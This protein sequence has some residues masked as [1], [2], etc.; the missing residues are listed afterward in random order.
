MGFL[1]RLAD[2]RGSDL[3]GRRE[4]PV[5]LLSILTSSSTRRQ[6]FEKGI[7]HK[8]SIPFQGGEAGSALALIQKQRFHLRAR[9]SQA[10]GP[11]CIG[12]GN[13]RTEGSILGD[14]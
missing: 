3:P 6:P 12:E 1:R 11:P 8:G 10:V 13:K 2:S 14:R 4:A 9:Q 5:H 7:D